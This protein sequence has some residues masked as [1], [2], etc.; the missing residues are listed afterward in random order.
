IEV[1]E[2][3]IK[4]NKIAPLGSKHRKYEKLLTLYVFAEEALIETVGLSANIR[5]NAIDFLKWATKHFNCVLLCKSSASIIQE[6]LN[7]PYMNNCFNKIQVVEITEDYSIEEAIDHYK[8][9]YIVSTEPLKGPDSQV[10]D[11]NKNKRYIKL[12]KKPIEHAQIK[13][14]KCLKELV[15]YK[16]KTAAI[17]IPIPE[18]VKVYR[19]VWSDD[20][21]TYFYNSFRYREIYEKGCLELTI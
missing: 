19:S 6:A 7:D 10:T 12:N 9:F 18:K 21:D 11:I 5:P 14:F 15:E 1:I 4:F 17:N 20:S 3:N 2:R 8:D 13:L 16:V